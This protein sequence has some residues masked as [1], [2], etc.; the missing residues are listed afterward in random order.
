MSLESGMLDYT[1]IRIIMIK[2]IHFGVI[3]VY[4]PPEGQDLRIKRLT[5]PIEKCILF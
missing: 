3:F 5:T 2:Q 4:I 1:E